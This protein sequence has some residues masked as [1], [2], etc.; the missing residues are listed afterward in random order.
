MNSTNFNTSK[1]FLSLLFTV[2]SF[3]ATSADIRPHIN[4]S[5]SYRAI[6]IEGEIV[7]GD[8]E[9]FISIVK[10][11]QGKVSGVYLF[12]PGG[13]FYEA[14]KIGRAIRTLELSSQA[15][16][17]DNS[18]SPICEDS[19]GLGITPLPKNAQNCTLASAGFFI[20]IGGIHKGGNFLAVH[21]PYFGKGEFGRLS[22]S[23]AKKAFDLLQQSARDYMVEM[24]VP[25]HIQ[26]DILGTPSDKALLLEEKVIKTHFWGK[27]PYYHEWI[28]NKCSKL[29]DAEQV[30]A[31]K[32]SSILRNTKDLSKQQMDDYKAIKKKQREEDNCEIKIIKQ[33]RID[34]YTKYFGITPSD[35]TDHDFSIWSDATKYI[36]K[37]FYKLLNEEKFKEEKFA[38]TNYLKRNVT[39][40]T[41][42]ISLSDLG[43]K[44]PRVVNSVIL[45]SAPNPSKEFIRLLLASLEKNWG[46]SMRVNEKEEW[47]WSKN[48]FFSK[49]KYNP[50][51]ASGA[52]ISLVIDKI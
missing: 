1:L 9:T 28:L 34:A 19:F 35:F 50:K 6:I 17:R 38:G 41:P 42:H 47:S 39:A 36:G 8:F 21:R 2:L 52:Y 18:G 32:Y 31:K 15:P 3:K 14:M 49:L 45:V 16:M 43:S 7:E 46:D 27:E 22:R 10:E 25:K 5:G 4:D 30:R 48:S 12:T 44:N 11:N 13:N 33:S 26:E 29:T 24:G 51:S 37:Q 40:N 23:D 20:H